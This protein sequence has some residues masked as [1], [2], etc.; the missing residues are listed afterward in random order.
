ML[1]ISFTHNLL[2]ISLKDFCDFCN[3]LCHVR[4]LFTHFSESNIHVIPLEYN[5]S[6][7]NNRNESVHS[8]ID[9]R[10]FKK[11]D[12][13]LLGYDKI[14]EPQSKLEQ[15]HDPWRSHEKLSCCVKTHA[16]DLLSVFNSTFV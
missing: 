8:E 10:L 15:V 16:K 5:Y 4:Q 11:S 13:P 3:V 12:F 1:S 7:V 14:K 6:F 9:E 2:T